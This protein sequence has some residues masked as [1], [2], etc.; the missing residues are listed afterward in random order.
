M[1]EQMAATSVRRGRNAPGTTNSAR[2][3]PSRVTP[4]AVRKRSFRMPEIVLGM[5]LVVGCALAAVLWQQHNTSTATVVVAAR[6]IEHGQLITAADLRG[7]QMGGETSAMISGD[8]AAALLGRVAVVDIAA[9]VPLTPTLLVETTPLAADE[10]LT[11]MA[12]A[13]GQV[14][15]DLA[16]NDRVRIVVTEPGAAAGVVATRLLDEPA[17]VWSV[18]VALDG[19]S[20]IVVVRGPLALSVAVAAATQV[21]VTRIGDG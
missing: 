11:S 6:P 7:A 9:G 14:P 19:V 15:P 18:D 10:A 4:A 21:H 16:V 17:T 5:F 1:A 2:H 8:S 13:P 20:T 12:L 3:G